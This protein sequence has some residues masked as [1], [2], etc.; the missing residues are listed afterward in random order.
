MVEHLYLLVVNILLEQMLSILLKMQQVYVI[1]HLIH[2]F[3]NK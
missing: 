2:D 1:F 3:K